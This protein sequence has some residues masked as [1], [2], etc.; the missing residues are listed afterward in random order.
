MF[1]E[2][3]EPES[4]L[5]HERINVVDENNNNLVN[6]NDG[7]GNPELAGAGD[8]AVLLNNENNNPIANNNAAVAVGPQLAL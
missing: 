1:D 7:L 6:N 4:E 3:P 2:L 5:I 8:A